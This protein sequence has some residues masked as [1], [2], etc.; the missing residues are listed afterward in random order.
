MQ[1][2]E[3]EVLCNNLEV[4]YR[5]LGLYS[6]KWVDLSPAQK[7]AWEEFAKTIGVKPSAREFRQLW[8]QHE[9]FVVDLCSVLGLPYEESTEKDVFNLVKELVTKSELLTDFFNRMSGLFSRK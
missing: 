3:G 8:N 6:Q 2:T 4:Q 7:G 9:T 1:K 5:K